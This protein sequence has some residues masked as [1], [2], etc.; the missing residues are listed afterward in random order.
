ML[1][2]EAPETR[3]AE[4]PDGIFIAYQVVGDGPVDVAWQFDWIGN[5]DLVWDVPMYADVFEGIA[6]FARLILHDRRA[7]GLSS[8]N[9]PPPNLETRAADLRVVLDTVG[10]PQPVLAGELEGGAA[11]VFFAASYPE[12]TKGVVWIQ[13]RARSVQ[14]DDYPWGTPPEELALI[15]REFRSWGTTEGARLWAESEAMH[16][17]VYTEEHIRPHT[18]L[19]RGTATPDVARQMT[20]NWHETD[21]R[22]ILPL[23]RAPTLLLTQGMV[24]EEVEEAEHV[25]SLLP[26]GELRRLPVGQ[27]FSPKVISAQVE[28]IRGFVG[29]E[30]SRP[31]FDTVLATVLF[32]DIVNSTERQS[33]LG[34]RAWKDLIER[35][36]V[37]VRSA[38]DQWRGVEMDTAGDGF[39]AT[40]DGPAR[41]IRCALDVAE[42]LKQLGI[43]IRAGVHAGE[44]EV[45]DGKVSGIAVSTG[46]RIASAAGRSEVLVSDTVKGLVAGSGFTFE[47]A[48]EHELKGVPER[49]RLYRVVA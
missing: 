8:G 19:S 44:C 20:E 27:L 17:H 22:S 3:Y 15:D 31:E 49:W 45:V 23:V 26:S 47:D 42:R 40:F 37:T 34:D 36:H 41:A 16:G 48:G 30:P 11:S 33:A 25:A 29:A 5:V 4:T 43:E 38:L 28:E 2:V 7:T 13:P 18:R 6:S 39:F 9:I 10:S 24:E 12:R 1:A 32:T 46:S 35:H 21:V 14:S